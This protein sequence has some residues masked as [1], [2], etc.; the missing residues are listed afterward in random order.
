MENAKPTHHVL[1]SWQSHDIVY[2][3]DFILILMMEKL[4]VGLF[5]RPS[6][7]DVFSRARQWQGLKNFKSEVTLDNKNF[8]FLKSMT[9]NLF[10]N[11]ICL[12]AHNSE[13]S[14]EIF[15]VSA[16][17]PLNKQSQH[18]EMKIQRSS[19]CFCLSAS[20]RVLRRNMIKGVS[21]AVSLAKSMR[22]RDFV[23]CLFVNCLVTIGKLI[24]TK[25]DHFNYCKA[26]VRE[27]HLEW[28]RYPKFIMQ[29]IYSRRSNAHTRELRKSGQQD[30]LK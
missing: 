17:D 26:Y 2:S 9:S 14:S 22:L 19:L 25:I 7:S 11:L 12:N 30:Y 13:R 10:H 23:I 27:I 1:L 24:E 4:R 15:T 18:T 16:V 6:T 8:R 28:N 3:C 5:W 29:I 20:G 21:E